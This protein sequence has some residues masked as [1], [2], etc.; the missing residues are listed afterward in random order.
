MHVLCCCALQVLLP[1][2]RCKLP[3][4]L[5]C[6]EHILLLQ[7]NHQQPPIPIVQQQAPAA[8]SQVPD[9]SGSVSADSQYE[10]DRQQ[11]LQH[12]YAPHR[13]RVLNHLERLLLAALEGQQAL[14]RFSQDLMFEL[15]G[16]AE[17]RGVPRTWWVPLEQQV[18]ELVWAYITEVSPRL[19]ASWLQPTELMQELKLCP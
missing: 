4:E 10:H 3:S 13:Y 19:R 9:A 5:T 16:P 18:L 8:A 14:L 6:L 2:L 15:Q 7:A 1:L 12:W 11:L 17:K